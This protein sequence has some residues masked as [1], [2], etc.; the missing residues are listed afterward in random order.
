MLETVRVVEGRFRQVFAGSPE[1]G[2]ACWRARGRGGAGA[3]ARASLRGPWSG[4]FVAREQ[5]QRSLNCCCR[6]GVQQ[7][8]RSAV[9]CAVAVEV[10]TFAGGAGARSAE[11]MAGCPALRADVVLVAL[12]TIVAAGGFGV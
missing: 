2:A 4:R 12:E 7:A 6:A 9:A 3:L 11:D 5:V 8:V 1:R 10:A